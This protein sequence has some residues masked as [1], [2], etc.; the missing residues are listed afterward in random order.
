MTVVDNGRDWRELSAVARK[1]ELFPSE[2]YF[3]EAYADLMTNGKADFMAQRT[4]AITLKPETLVSGRASLVL[5][6]LREKS[7]DP[8]LA[9]VFS[10]SRCSIREIW[11]YQWNIA[12][13]ERLEVMERLMCDWASVWILAW[14]L[15]NPP[16]RAGWLPATVRFRELKGSA[17]P[18][19]QKPGQLRTLLDGG[20]RTLTFVHA[21][22]EPIDVVRELGIQFAHSDRLAIIESWRCYIETGATVLEPIDPFVADTA[23]YPRHDLDVKAAMRRMLHHARSGHSAELRTL[24][25]KAQ[26]GAPLKA[27]RMFELLDPEASEGLRWDALLVGTEYVV[28]DMPNRICDIDDDGLKEWRSGLG[29]VVAA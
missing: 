10:H 2:S 1:A 18:E 22:D 15:S 14:D 20:N 8:F 19:F 24:L 26:A 7:F 28:H 27:R 16:P 21:A 17:V 12:T 6:Y 3:R 29:R 5:D 13:L 23:D 25:L 4:L 9:R 11:R